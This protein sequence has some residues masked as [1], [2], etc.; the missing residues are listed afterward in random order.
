MATTWPSSSPTPTPLRPCPAEDS[1]GARRSPPIATSP[2]FCPRCLPD[3]RRTWSLLLM[4]TAFAKPDLSALARPS[5]AFAMLAVDQ[6]EAMRAMFAEHQSEPVS[7]EQVTGFKLAATRTLTPYASA[8][9]L[10]KQFV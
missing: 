10:D 8:V 6:R 7:D 2:N 1:T 5:G 9:L 4:T 3:Q